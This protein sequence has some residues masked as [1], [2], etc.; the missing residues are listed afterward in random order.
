VWGAIT[1]LV[2]ADLTRG[3]GHYNLAQGGV[4]SAQGIGASLSGLCAGVVV[5]HFGYSAAFLTQ[6]AIAAVAFVALLA[7]MPET[8][9]ADQ[10]VAPIAGEAADPIAGS[11]SG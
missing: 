1:P 9:P 5:D 7:A 8:R 4:A 10:A 6:A 2:I 11:G 3:S